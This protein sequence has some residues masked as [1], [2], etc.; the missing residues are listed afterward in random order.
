MLS[1]NTDKLQDAIQDD[2]ARTCAIANSWISPEILD[3][4]IGDFFLRG[5]SL[6]NWK[7]MGIDR[8]FQQYDNWLRLELGD[9][10]RLFG[11]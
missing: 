8:S 3:V 9:T 1:A 5:H 4:L 11:I 7:L 2:K 6:K 10:N